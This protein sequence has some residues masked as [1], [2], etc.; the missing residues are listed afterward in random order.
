MRT[1][2]SYVGLYLCYLRVNWLALMAYP[3]EFWGNNLGNV[4]GNLLGIA[5]VGIVFGHVRAIGG[6]SFDQVLF[7]YALAMVA[8]SLW[9]LFMVNCLNLP[10]YV[11]RGTLDRLM[12]RPVNILFQVYAD[13]LD[14]DDWGEAVIGL[15]VLGTLSV[16]LGLVGVGPEVGLA[17]SLTNVLWLAVIALSGTAIFAAIHL[18]ANTTSFW[19]VQAGA[20]SQLVWQ[21]DGFSRYPL[22]VY[23]RPLRFVLSWLLPFGF[24]NFYPAHL[25]FGPSGVPEGGGLLWV[26][27]L[28][29]L[30]AAAA[31]GLAYRFWQAGLDH[32]QGAGS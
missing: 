2:G 26:A 16:R 6:W 15:V 28:T 24:I 23:S 5:A 3:T 13:Y 1:F 20:V 29:P 19:L 22:N 17:R 10:Y 32:Y 31:F 11:Q 27:R 9:H 25:F 30:V 14:N 21:V 8:R 7:L 12:V 18:A 4:A